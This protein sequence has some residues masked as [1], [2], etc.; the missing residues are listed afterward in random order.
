MQGISTRRA[1]EITRE[2][3][4]L[5][6]TS[7]GA[8][9]AAAELGTQLTAWRERPLGR[10]AFNT[11][12]RD[13]AQSAVRA[14][15]VFA[16]PEPHCRRLRTTNALE[17]STGGCI[18]Q[19]IRGRDGEPRSQLVHGYGNRRSRATVRHPRAGTMIRARSGATWFFLSA[20]W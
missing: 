17:S 9:R 12:E 5:D 14:L 11:S 7:T 15:G 4:G 10:C 8:S 18:E 13:E 16:L 6:V 19:V 2:L 3:C 1:T 20:S